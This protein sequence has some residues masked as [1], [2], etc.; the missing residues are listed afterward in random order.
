M[1]TPRPLRLALAAALAAIA[2]GDD[3][4]GITGIDP[5]TFALVRVVNATL[6]N[7]S[8]QL[9]ANGVAIGVPVAASSAAGTC[10]EVPT[11]QTLTFRAEGTSTDLASLPPTGLAADRRYEIAVYGTPGSTLHGSPTGVV[12]TVLADSAQPAPATNFTGIRFF[13]GT[14]SAVD[15]YLAL[16]EAPLPGQL[17]ASSLAPGREVEGGTKFGIYSSALTEVRVFDP[18]VASGTPRFTSS[19]GASAFDPNRVWTFVLSE[20]IAFGS[21]NASFLVAPCG[22]D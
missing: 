5:Q 10:F 2:C 18:G 16:P 20:G 1:S 8:L 13:N 4:S 11:N 7:T 6:G 14:R 22:Q 12:A 21:I 3:S 17:V 9:F 15:V 19:V